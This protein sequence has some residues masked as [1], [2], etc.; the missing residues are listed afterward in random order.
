MTENRRQTIEEN[1]RQRTEDSEAGNSEQ[2]EKGR[3]Q[4]AWGIAHRA[5]AKDELE[6]TFGRGVSIGSEKE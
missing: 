4:R 3:E 1:R 2:R 5:E 6:E